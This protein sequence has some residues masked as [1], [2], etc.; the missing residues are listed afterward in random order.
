M[1]DNRIFFFIYFYNP[2][3]KVFA[4][5]ETYEQNKIKEAT[6]TQIIDLFVTH[7]VLGFPIFILF[8]WIMFEATF[9]LGAYPMEW[10][11]NLVSWIG[12]FVRGNMSEGPLKDLLVDGIIGGVGGVIVFLPNILILYLFIARR[13]PQ[14]YNDR[15]MKLAL[16]GK[17]APAS[18]TYTGKRALQ[19]ISGLTSMVII[20]LLRL[21]IVREAIIAGTLQPNPITKGMKDLPWSPILCMIL[22][23]MKAARAI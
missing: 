10:I 1:T 2:L 12:N 23:I 3:E 4:L 16:L 21:S 17:N 11:E 18:N 7:K 15:R 19:L 5:R 6:S 14:T 20:R 8:M 22:S 13:I 9:R